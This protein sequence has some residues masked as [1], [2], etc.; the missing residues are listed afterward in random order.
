M[1]LTLEYEKN[2]VLRFLAVWTIETLLY[3]F[4]N[5]QLEEPHVTLCD[6]TEG[7]V[8]IFGCYFDESVAVYLVILQVLC[9]LEFLH[10]IL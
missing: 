9:W 10:C 2:Y 5:V 3:G 8:L 4:C 6:L 7:T 1:V